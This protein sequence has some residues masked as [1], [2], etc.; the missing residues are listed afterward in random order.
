MPGNEYLSTK[1]PEIINNN[2]NSH[3]S[4]LFAQTAGWM[5]PIWGFVTSLQVYLGLRGLGFWSSAAPCMLMAYAF[6][7]VGG[8]QHA[9]WAFLTVLQQSP[10]VGH[11]GVDYLED[12]Q[13][14]I[15][16]HYIWGDL[17]GITSLMVSSAWI[18][19]VVATQKSAFPRYFNLFN[20]LVTQSWVFALVYMLPAPW[21]GYVGGP[22]GTWIIL[23]LN[24]ATS[25][26]LWDHFEEEEGADKKES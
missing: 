2:Q 21:A 15:W 11:C 12:T 6:C 8:S 1:L 22:F 17:P 3:S 10:L 13:S 19:I 18:G 4:I 20:P 16:R 5:Y 9:S 26:G 14:R 23:G 24:V 7:V 25:Y